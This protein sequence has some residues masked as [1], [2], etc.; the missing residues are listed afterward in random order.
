[1]TDLET[2]QE[3]SAAGCHQECLQACQNALQVNSEEAFAYKYAGKSLLALGQIEKAQ[4]CLVKAHQLDG[5]D[6]EIVKDIGNTFNTIQNS[7]E[8][9]KYYKLSLSINPNYPPA[10]NNLGLIAKQQG[11]LPVAKQLIERARDLDPTFTISHINLSVIY[12]ELGEPGQAIASLRE[13]M[14][15]E[16]TKEKAAIELAKMY[17]YLGNYRDGL[18]AI[19]GIHNKAADNLRL[20]LSLC[21]D[22][23]LEFNRCAEDLISKR[24]LNQR[25][26]AAIDHANILYDQALDNGLGGSTIDSVIF[27]KINKQ[28]FSDSFIDEILI[29]LSNGSIQSKYQGLL[30][31]GSQTSG[32]IFDIPEKPFQALREL[33]VQKIDNYNQTCD[34]N[35]DKD[36]G[37]NWKKNMY[38]LTGTA[39]T[40]DKG[41]NL[42]SHNHENQET[43][44]IT[45]T[46][47]LQM[48]E[49]EAN[50]EAG[51]IEFSHRG[52]RY[53]EGASAFERRVIRPTAR[54]LNIFSSSLF[55]RTLPFQ[56]ET[57]RICIAF[58]VTRN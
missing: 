20:S 57:Q 15:S 6:P 11:C 49:R 19:C 53:P 35:T 14:K 27:Q 44:W 46:F 50:S 55:H 36:F 45:G 3:L 17:Y 54:D 37:A 9:A 24:W 7:Q 1:M 12:Q 22:D 40:M 33:L 26:V 43:S 28:E 32:N 8:A 47:Y 56:S 34:I 16:K 29:R 48:P 2:I 51:A 23:K 13:A 52:P 10:L 21:L 25:G 4:Q 18:K 5:S 38:T 31:N 58:E 41:G 42:R 39:M 30:A